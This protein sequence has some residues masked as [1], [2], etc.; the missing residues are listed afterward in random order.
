[1]ATFL[2]ELLTCEEDLENGR[3]EKVLEWSQEPPIEKF[4]L[5]L[6]V[7]IFTSIVGIIWNDEVGVSLALEGL[8]IDK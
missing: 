4:L 6:E 8:W 1:M 2:G 3:F 5:V 7:N